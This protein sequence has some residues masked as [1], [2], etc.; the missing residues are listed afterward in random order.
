MADEF[1][2]ET[3]VLERAMQTLERARAEQAQL[4][5]ER[6]VQQEKLH[7]LLAETF[8]AEHHPDVMATRAAIVAIQRRKF[9]VDN[10]LSRAM[11]MLRVGTT[12]QLEQPPLPAAGITPT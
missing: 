4:A 9:V 3:D 5:E 10:A 8:G 1:E 6:A 12:M 2:L 7:A 11:R